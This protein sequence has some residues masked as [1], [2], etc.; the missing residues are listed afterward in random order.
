MDPLECCTEIARGLKEKL[1]T[2]GFSNVRVEVGPCRES[3][4]VV[5]RE[6]APLFRYYW[7]ERVKTSQV[8]GY[9]IK[10]HVEW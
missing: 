1:I 10:F 7:I 8:V 2:D 3:Y 6:D 4:D 9:A 5:K